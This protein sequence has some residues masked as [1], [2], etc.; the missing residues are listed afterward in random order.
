LPVAARQFGE[1]L[2]L[3]VD[4]SLDRRACETFVGF[5]GELLR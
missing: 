3:S 5:C 2:R 4:S 1:N